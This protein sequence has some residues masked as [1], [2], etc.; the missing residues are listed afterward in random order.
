VAF[1]IIS[2]G[3]FMPIALADLSRSEKLFDAARRVIPGG[4]GSNDRALVEPH[5]IFIERGEGAYLFDVDGNRY[6]DYLL[7]YG[8][9]VLGHAHPA[10]IAAVTEQLRRGSMYGASHPLEPEVGA[11]LVD[12]LPGIDMVRFGSSGTEAVLAAMRL[13]RAATQRRYIVKFEGQYHGWTDQVA[14]SYA[15]GPDDAGSIARP[16]VVP[17]SEGIPPGIVDD[18]I[19]MGW[20]DLA[21]L[22]QLLGSMGDEVAGVLTEPICCNFGV[23]EPDPGYLQGLRALC[24]RHGAV[25]IFDE[26]QTGFR[27]GLRGAQG[28]LG[29]VPDLTCLGKAMSAGFP[30]SAIGGRADIMELIGDRR[31]LQAGT[32][33]TNPLGLAAVAATIEVVSEPG[34]FEH[35]ARLSQDLRAG[36]ADLV[37]PIGGYVQG[38]TTV[39]GV[40]FG[41]GPIR[42]MRDG[43][44]NDVDRVM[45]FKRELRLRG[46]YTKP[47]PRDI[48]YVSTAHTDADVAITLEVATDAAKAARSVPAFA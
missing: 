44:R 11:A 48:W 10:I 3:I 4:V 18:T 14:L 24:D 36:L 16:R 38:S 35:M 45:A 25:L 21:A 2:G 6:I 8:P 43:W 37:A 28:L 26:V 34:C 22:E 7:G 33:N 1:S 32:Y 40:A 5:P 31:V 27:I 20:N 41:P 9:L 47:T 39:F 46:V 17:G 23:I 30:V 29:V 15:P 13:A 42:N 19:V 12:L